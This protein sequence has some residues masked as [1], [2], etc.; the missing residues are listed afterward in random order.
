MGAIA[1]SG[2]A[3]ATEEIGRK[4]VMHVRDRP[5]S[6]KRR[7]FAAVLGLVIA[8]LATEF[9]YRIFRSGVLS[10]TTNP[11]YVVHDPRLGW[12]LRPS[13]S[14]RQRTP[15]FDVAIAINSRGFRGPEWNLAAAKSRPR[16]LVLGDSF[17]FGWGVEY[18]RSLC[19][20][21]A[22]LEPEWDVYCAAV[23]GYGTDQEALL[24]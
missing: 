17:A 9:G 6:L 14:G 19:G 21:L 23:S 11:A 4:E 15:E 18:E 22:A 16:V 2:P 12:S 1:T 3:H 13:A 24:L 8:L 7:I 5:K 20:R 10:P